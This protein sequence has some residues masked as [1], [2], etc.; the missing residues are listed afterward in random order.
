MSMTS[1]NLNML[2]SAYS[3]N[4]NDQDPDLD[5]LDKG[6]NSFDGEGGDTNMCYQQ[7]QLPYQMDK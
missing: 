5:F 2:N 6:N 7:E 4:K 3:L 1:S